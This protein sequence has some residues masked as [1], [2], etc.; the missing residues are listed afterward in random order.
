[1]SS[2][3]STLDTTARPYLILAVKA[4][5]RERRLILLAFATLVIAAAAVRLLTFD[6]YLPYFDYSDESV[7]F[8]VA[9]NWRGLFDD[10]YVKWRYAGYPPAYPIINIGV[11]YLVELFAVHPWTVP[12]DYFYALRLLASCS[13]SGFHPPNSS[14]ANRRSIRCKR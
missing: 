5:I 11:Q 1:M 12:P 9:R 3:T 10:E 14:S 2:V 13:S 8:L 6:R 7:P 4:W